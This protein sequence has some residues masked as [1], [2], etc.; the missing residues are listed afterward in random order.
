MAQQA[1]REQAR[2][3]SFAHAVWP[4][5]Q[6]RVGQATAGYGAL[7][8]FLLPLMADQI[9][10]L[11]DF[12]KLNGWF[13]FVGG[14]DYAQL[15][16]RDGQQLEDTLE[17][18]DIGDHALHQKVERIGVGRI[19]R[20]QPAFV[21]ANF[22]M[23]GRLCHEQRPQ[24][25]VSEQGFQF[26]FAVAFDDEIAIEFRV[27][28]FDILQP[29]QLADSAEQAAARHAKA[30]VV[31]IDVG[32]PQAGE[33]YGNLA[34]VHMKQV[35]RDSPVMVLDFDLVALPCPTFDEVTADFLAELFPDFLDIRA[36]E[37]FEERHE[38]P[39]FSK[40]DGRDIFAPW[41]RPATLV[42]CTSQTWPLLNRKRP[43]CFG[44]L[45]IVY[46]F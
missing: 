41:G 6:K 31:G 20:P 24:S 26:L 21:I 36:K 7:E 33:W 3:G 25:L 28:D 42:A 22:E 32:R 34:G 2:E 29:Q 11:H 1:F 35:E 19:V 5:E 30:E 37:P 40:T 17:Q 14:A 45:A 12:S 9:I 46:E 38:I 39:A 27:T 8:P 4:Q 16:E 23:N 44:R 10:P 18:L 13:G 15:V 43:N